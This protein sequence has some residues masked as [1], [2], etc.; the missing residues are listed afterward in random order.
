MFGKG[1]NLLSK[2]N[3]IWVSPRSDDNSWIVKRSGVTRP[4]RVFNNQ[5]DAIDYGRNYAAKEKT[6]L[7]IQGRNGKIRS[8][9]SYGNDPLPPRDTEH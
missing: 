4:A 2:S 3:S 1:G 5:K 9:D 7:V 6:E 8:K